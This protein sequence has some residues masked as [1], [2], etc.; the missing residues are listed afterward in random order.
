M[1]GS[2][3]WPEKQ[4]DIVYQALN[5]VRLL[6]RAM[7][8]GLTVVHGNAASGVDRMADHWAAYAARGVVE[9]EV[10]RY[11]ADWAQLGKSAGPIR[12]R[13]MAEAGADL[14]LAFLHEPEGTV[15]KGT[16]DMI[17]V[18]EIW[19]IPAFEIHWREETK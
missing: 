17:H 7:G 9:V 16:R 13:E 8:E 11:P 6:A 15:S 4:E 18:A 5:G 3:S 1:T 14:C 12:N 19:S 10:E 2:R